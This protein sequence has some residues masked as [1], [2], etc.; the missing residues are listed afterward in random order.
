MDRFESLQ[1]FTRIV[2]SGSFSQAAA[3]LDIPRAT[4]THAIKALESRLGTRLLERTTRHVRPTLDGQA[5]Y[6]RCVSVLSELDDAEASLQHIASNPRGTLRVDMH[7]TH[8][9]QIVLPAIPEFRE[10]YPGIDLVV[11]SGD[12]LVDLVR[13]GVDCVIRAGTPRDSSLVARRLAALPQAICASPEYLARFGTPTH[14]DDLA[15]HQAVKFFSSSGASDYPL[16]LIVDGKVQAYM[17][18]GWMSVNDAENYY[19]CGLRGCGLIQIP[20]FHMEEALRDGRLVEVLADW[21]SPDMPLAAFYPHHRQLSPRVRVFIDWLTKLYE[22]R[23]GP[24]P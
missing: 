23:F 2:E 6:E 1:L 24:L 7:G 10:R 12:R 20:R 5:F 21:R 9:T 18:D 4:A 13:E 16:E 15:Q 14:P 19:V 22:T 8:A 17:L 11:S 3:S